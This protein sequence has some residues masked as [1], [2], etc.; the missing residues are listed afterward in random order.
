M[1]KSRFAYVAYDTIAAKLQNQL[2]LLCTQAESDILK[3]ENPSDSLAQLHQWV[4]ATSDT[5]IYHDL[6][7]ESVVGAIAY[8][9]QGQI[10]EAMAALEA[11]YFWVGKFVRL[12]QIARNEG[13]TK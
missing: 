12:D 3:G 6:A 11:T 1:I 13:A 2:R 8:L 7:Q 9:D 10:P 5:N 4:D